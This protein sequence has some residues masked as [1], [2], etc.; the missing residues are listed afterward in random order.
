[1]DNRVAL[2]KG[3]INLSDNN[4]NILEYYI[5]KEVG[6]GGASIAYDAFYRSN[7]GATIPVRI[8]ECYPYKLSLTRTPANTLVPAKMDQRQFDKCKEKLALAFGVQAELF[9][10]NALTN[11]ISAPCN[12]YHANNTVYVVTS[13]S[14]GRV[15]SIEENYEL[16][17][18]I[19]LIKSITTL[20]GKVH[21]LGYLYLDIKPDNVWVLTDSY[22]NVQLFDFDSLIP[23]NFSK[24]E[25]IESGISYSKG[26]APIEQQLANGK[27]IGKWSDVYS[28]GALFYYL[29]FKKVPTARETETDAK[30][31][32]DQSICAGRHYDNKLYGTLEKFLH[33]TLTSYYKD[34][35]QN[36]DD[37]LSL[38]KEIE[39]ISIEKELYIESR[40]VAAPPFFV[41]REQELERLNAWYEKRS[42]CIVVSGLEGL[43]KSTLIAKFFSDLNSAD[44]SVIWLNYTK[45]LRD[46]VNSE[47]QLHIN[48]VS[49]VQGETD[50]EYYMRKMRALKDSVKNDECIIVLDDYA[51]DFDKCFME[52]LSAD[53]RIIVISSRRVDDERFSKLEIAEIDED[54]ILCQIMDHY[55]NRESSIGLTEIYTRIINKVYRNTLIIELVSKCIGN[56]YFSIDEICEKINIEGIA[57]FDLEKVSYVKNSD[58]Y[59]DTIANIIESV[60]SVG[61]V[62]VEK[63]RI[64]KLF[65]II[66][67]EGLSIEDVKNIN[68]SIK[69]DDVNELKK[70]GWLTGN[71][72]IYIHPLLREAILASEWSDDDREAVGLSIENIYLKIRLEGEKDQVPRKM[73]KNFVKMREY[74]KLVKFYEKKLLKKG[75]LGKMLFG[76]MNL[77]DYDKPINRDEIQ[78]YLRYLKSWLDF[79]QRYEEYKSSEEYYECLYAIFL[80]TPVDE[81]EL[82]L[83]Y[84]IKLINVVKKEV[85][86]MNVAEKLIDILV[87]RGDEQGVDKYLYIIEKYVKQHGSS[88]VKGRYYDL[89]AWCY[90][91]TL[92]GDYC[93]EYS[94]KR[95]IEYVDKSIYYIKKSRNLRANNLYIKYMLGKVNLLMRC[96]PGAVAE[97]D[98]LINEC[99]VIVENNSLTISK[100]IFR[101]YMVR[102]RYYTSIKS[103]LMSTLACIQLAFGAVK[104]CDISAVEIIDEISVPSAD[105]LREHKE[106][107]AAQNYLRLAMKLCEEQADAAPYQRKSEELLFYLND[108]CTEAETQ[109]K[110]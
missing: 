104:E 24:E 33:N 6:R 106:Y 28:V 58:I 26:F 55:I 54:D 67:T 80:N 86:F 41:G 90:E 10:S 77:V 44:L 63:Q 51:G 68:S 5:E 72:I 91:A 48:S 74:P 37:V 107:K 39:K 78:R 1:M 99:R 70:E 31:D 18:V 95:L 60:F 82:C 110:M 22:E 71:K 52:L 30:F 38:I 32:F 64:L 59:V 14:Q 21:S 8:K 93:D 46:T 49:R 3:Q 65:S 4:G 109:N 108:L 88:Y 57:R 35:F 20:I 73:V 79:A 43:G 25:L 84:A 87:S 76:H 81:E 102:A 100:D 23:I 15:I 83:D 17:D 47:E 36:M 75:T 12:I 61:K 62:Q 34:R 27:Q 94:I 11:N 105:M 2:E 53:W 42:K 50:D 101:Y 66:A 89:L 97:I 9:N 85:L 69:S 103:D 92:G 98:H 19:K 29:L 7:Q 45:S 56:G 40:Y 13:Y 96:T 16:S